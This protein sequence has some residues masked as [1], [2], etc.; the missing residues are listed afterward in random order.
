[1]NIFGNYAYADFELDNED[2]IAKFN[3][4]NHRFTV[5]TDGRRVWKDLGFGLAY[6][7]QDEFLYESTFSTGNV[8]AFGTLDAQLNWTFPDINTQLKIG[9]TNLVGD[10]Y[11]TISGG[12]LIGR[13]YYVGLTYN[14]L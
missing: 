9:G 5:G 12:P 8:P 6:R 4:P 13:T 14:N 2:F 3:T 7:W 1:M 10:G 11:Q